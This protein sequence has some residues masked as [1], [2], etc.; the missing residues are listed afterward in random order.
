MSFEEISAP[1]PFMETAAKMGLRHPIEALLCAP[2]RYE[3]YRTVINDFDV[4]GDAALT[5][6]VVVKLRVASDAQG[7][8]SIRGYGRKG[9]SPPK[10]GYRDARRALYHTPFTRGVFRLEIDVI[11]DRGSRAI[12]S[13]FGAVFQWREIQADQELLI[14]ATADRGYGRLSF[15]NATVI[16]PGN[17]G[18]I[19]PVYLGAP[20]KHVNS[21]EVH[22]LVEW[23]KEE[24]GRLLQATL[25]ATEKIR[26]DCGGLSDE[27]ILEICTPDESPFRPQTIPELLAS[28]HAPTQSIEEGLAARE[29]V[30]RICIFSLQC[31]AQRQ[32]A[33]PPCPGSAIG[34]ADN[35]IRVAR[36]LIDEVEGRRGFSLTSNQKDVIYGVVDRIS[37]DQPL[38]GLLSGEVGAGKTLAY[39]V[40]AAVAHLSGARV[41]IM[42]PTTLLADQIAKGIHKEFA[43]KVQVERVLRGK[44]I[45]NPDAILVGTVGMNTVAKKHGWVPNLLI[46]DEQHKLHTAAREFLAQPFTHTL[47]VSATPIPR[48]LALS[49][50]EGL[51]VF[52][53]NEQPVKKDIVTHLIDVK[54][55]RYASVALRK[56]LA[57]G[58]R[59]AI[60]FTLVDPQE[61]TP[62][63]SLDAPEQRKVTKEEKEQEEVALKAAIDS[64]QLFERDFPGQ[65]S[66]L[67]GKMTDEE[68]VLALDA[69]RDGSKPLMITTT[70]FETGIDVP[71]VQIVI[72]RDPQ[73]L[74]LSQLHQLRGRL[75]RTGGKGACFLLTEDLY[76]L[77]DDTYRRL[78][79]FCRTMDGY[80]LA[81]EDLLSRG[82]GDL[83]G[84]QQKGRANTLFKGVKL[85]TRD[86]IFNDTAR[87]DIHVQAQLDV[88]AHDRAPRR[89]QQA[90]DFS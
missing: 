2:D 60:V 33:R 26:E 67:H 82:A 49:L 50:Y 85:T 55:R 57:E 18:K 56:V 11:D 36:E 20:G 62:S 21:A 46:L 90:F 41:A 87:A 34:A 70:I 51:D 10:G 89:Q 3:D 84:L 7:R 40:P 69:F 65:V 64:A 15:N 9:A 5:D 75:A 81:T 17:I 61:G 28:L 58:G 22:A 12:I 13:V 66:L 42:A 68:K 25:A 38:N 78:E 27:D 32:N 44:R 14:R 76:A 47:D 6:P 72:I 74:G 83:E 30:K 48:S 23:V 39:A 16:H 45:R 77:S 19:A 59:C 88:E 80:Q 1:A 54:D 24:E 73:Q 31:V 79:V 63:A 43:G 71:D 53:L 37:T 52:T 35:L 86:L 4:I 8:P 29:I